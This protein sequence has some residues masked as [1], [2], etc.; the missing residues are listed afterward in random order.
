MVLNALVGRIMNP[1]QELQALQES[2]GYLAEDD[3]RALSERTRIPLYELGAVSSF[4]PHFRRTPPPPVRV[5]MCRDLSCHLRD[6]ERESKR[7]DMALVE[8]GLEIGRQLME[9]TI[10]GQ[11]QVENPTPA[12]KCPFGGTDD[13]GSSRDRDNGT[14]LNEVGVMSALQARRKQDD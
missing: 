11:Q 9:E 14:Y 3:L 2:R 10:R 8:A 5:G 4:Y 6:G 13:G 12:S 1:I 7:I